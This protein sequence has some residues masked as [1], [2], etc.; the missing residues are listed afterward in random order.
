MTRA[1]MTM[2]ATMTATVAGLMLALCAPAAG[3][4]RITLAKVRDCERTICGGLDATHVGAAYADMHKQW[5]AYCAAVAKRDGLPAVRRPA[6]AGDDQQ[7]QP[8]W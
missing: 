8:G 6:A 2:T 3:A 5:L 7:K 1:T 4:E